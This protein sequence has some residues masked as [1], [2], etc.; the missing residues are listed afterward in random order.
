MLR[1]RINPLKK[2]IPLILSAIL[3]LPS[4]IFSQIP[5]SPPRAEGEGPFEHMI[6][7]GVTL[8]NG[9]GAPPTGPVDIE[10]ENNIITGVHTVGYPGIEIPEN[11]RPAAQNNTHEIDAH[12]MYAL[13]G[14]VDMHGHMGGSSQGTPAEYVFKLW[15]AHGI[16]TVRDPGSYNGLEWSLRHKQKSESN[17]ITA[18]RFHIYLSFGRSHDGT[19][20]SPEEARRWVRNLAQSGGD[21]IKFFGLRPDIMEAALDEANSRGLGTAMHHAQMNVSWMNALDSA[22]LGLGTIEHWYGIPEAMLDGTTVQNYP[23]TYNFMNE[24]HRFEEAGRL[25]KQA[26]KPGSEPWQN[27]IS[28]LIDLDVTLVP[29]FNIYDANRD[30]M[31]A[32]RAEWHD[33]YTLPS[34]WDFFHPSR[35][36]H[37]SYWFNWGTEQEILWK[38]NYRI[39][40]QFVNDYKNRGGRV[41]T[42]SDS[43][44]IYQI[45]G[46]GFI[47]ELEMLREAGFHPLEVIRA[48]TLAG[49]EAIGV[50]DKVGTIEPGKKADIVL[51]GSNPLENF[52]VLYGTGAIIL[53]EENE[54]VRTEGIRYTIKDGI[55]FD[56][57]ELLRDVREIVREAK[58]REG[59]E[60][61]LQPGVSE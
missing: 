25:W 16:T 8:I 13:P 18:P 52:Q 24:Q 51:S 29:T 37:G 45:Y 5:D 44:Y 6:I 50:A 57:R 11:R 12:G 46:F 31:R 55:V 19:I 10:I 22:R 28:E 39:W 43:G 33:E 4:L 53:N 41:A 40:M 61:L 34:L 32:R 15:L 17:E 27:L 21:G 58:E 20:Q 60:N 14:F 23:A 49:A 42:G 54:A 47:R 59:R 36:A 7:R 26:A 9:N 48:G 30:F 1:A 56:A 35:I 38:E 3:L 2:S